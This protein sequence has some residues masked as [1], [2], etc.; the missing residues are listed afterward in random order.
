MY[1]VDLPRPLTLVVAL[2]SM[3][4]PTSVFAREFPT[5]DAPSADDPTVAAL[6]D[7]GHLIEEDSPRRLQIRVSHSRQPRVSIEQTRVGAIDLNRTNAALIGTF[8][9]SMTPLS[10]PFLFRSS[11]HV[12]NVLNGPTEIPNSLKPC[13]FVGL[14]S[15]DCPARA[16]DRGVRPVKSLTRLKGL[17]GRKQPSELTS[18]IVEALG[19]EPIRSPHGQ[20][21][22]RCAASLKEGAEI[23]WPSFVTTHHC[24]YAA[25]HP[26]SDHAMSHVQM[27]PP[28]A[29]QSLPSEDRSIFPDAS[30]RAGGLLHENAKDFTE[31]SR[32]QAES[33]GVAMVTDFDRKPLEG[34]MTATHN[35]TRRDSA[36]A[37]LIDRIRKVE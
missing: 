32:Q 27:M 5:A 31:Y 6:H 22:T 16:I 23:N 25:F 24:K 7:M 36:A 2:F 34:A 26:F 1:R 30:L 10:M 28:K 3:A 11:E 9:P 14:T 29:W 12:Q 4:A 17:K 13:G 15:Y 19:A 20:V 33:A 35:K 21:P 8:V 18:D 37:G